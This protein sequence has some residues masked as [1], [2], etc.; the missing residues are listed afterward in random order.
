MENHIIN[1]YY[2]IPKKFGRGYWFIKVIPKRDL[3][4]QI[5][6]QVL[7]SIR[8][9]EMIVP[10]KIEIQED[11]IL[12]YTDYIE[13]TALSELLKVQGRFSE[14]EVAKIGIQLCDILLKLHNHNPRIIYRDMKPENILMN[15]RGK[16]F[17][18][19]F[20]TIWIDMISDKSNQECV[21]TKG[22]APFEQYIQ[23]M[24]LDVVTDIYALGVTFMEL[25]TNERPWEQSSMEIWIRK[26][27]SSILPELLELIRCCTQ[28]LMQKRYQSC[29]KVKEILKR[30]ISV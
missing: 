7:K 22:Y 20:D 25:L 14:R 16:I 19:D 27:E 8:C 23:G 3:N 13:A 24:K 6:I 29:N 15:Q 9:K 17:L 12:L 2:K 11:H 10:K 26:W 18:I 1:K 28:E 30:I 4:I 21:G 5:N